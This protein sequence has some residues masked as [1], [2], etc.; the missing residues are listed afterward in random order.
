[1]ENTNDIWAI[2]MW[3]GEPDFWE[4]G[5]GSKSLKLLVDYIF[6]NLKA[7]KII[8]DPHIDNPRAIHVYEKAGFKKVKILK[9]H[10]N[11]KDKKVD[12][13]LMEIDK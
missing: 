7:E 10:E 1:M 13:W 5:I 11:Y 9:A 3:I 4:K 8:I 12:A 2:D 6:K